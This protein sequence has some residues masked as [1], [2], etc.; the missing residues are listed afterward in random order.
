MIL[1]VFLT[2]K[3]DISRGVH[4]FLNFNVCTHRRGYRHTY[5]RMEPFPSFSSCLTQYL[6][7]QHT[8]CKH[9][10]HLHIMN[11]QFQNSSH[12]WGYRSSRSTSWSF[13]WSYLSCSGESMKVSVFE[14][15]E[16]NLP[17]NRSAFCEQLMEN[18]L[19]ELRRQKRVLF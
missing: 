14:L 12:T 17:K 5:K 18:I 15:E 9:F 10:I 16:F 7:E 2:L 19:R 11:A 8:G 13:L 4:F 1:K 6:T 3:V